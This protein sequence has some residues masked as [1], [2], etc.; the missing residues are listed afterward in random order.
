MNFV[1]D[2]LSKIKPS[3]T[4]GIN[5][6]AKALKDEGKD[7]IVLAAGEPDF[8]TPKNIRDAA[9]KQWKRVKQNMYQVKVHQNYKKQFRKNLEKI[10]I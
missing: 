6:K 8:N 9:N 1:A 3:M 2:R 10:I 4:V 5:V 7:V